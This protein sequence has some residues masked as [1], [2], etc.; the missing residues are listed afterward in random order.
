MDN[1]LTFLVKLRKV[2]VSSKSYGLVRSSDII[3]ATDGLSKTSTPFGT[4]MNLVSVEDV[5]YGNIKAK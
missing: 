3:S 5:L 1:I 4:L 2:D